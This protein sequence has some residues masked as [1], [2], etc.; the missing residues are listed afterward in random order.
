[1][2]R[3]E[4]QQRRL[5]VSGTSDTLINT[6]LARAT[7]LVVQNRGAYGH[8][9]SL[10]TSSTHKRTGHPETSSREHPDT[11]TIIWYT[12]TP[13]LLFGP[14]VAQLREFCSESDQVGLTH[15]E[16]LFEEPIAFPDHD[17]GSIETLVNGN[18]ADSHYTL[19]EHSTRRTSRKCSQPRSFFPATRISIPGHEVDM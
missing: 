17:I 7:D 6:V 11:N 9:G 15:F 19:L 3:T 16:L 14:Q 18:F 1:M 5:L 13:P 4:L 12:R 10:S 2:I 8:R